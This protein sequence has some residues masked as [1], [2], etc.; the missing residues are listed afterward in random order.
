MEKAVAATSYS[1]IIGS[2]N[3]P[4]T[5]E[6]HYL[7]ILPDQKELNKQQL[8]KPL[9]TNKIFILEPEKEQIIT[10]NIHLINIE[11]QLNNL[12]YNQRYCFQFHH[13]QNTNNN[14]TREYIEIFSTYLYSNNDINTILNFITNAQNNTRY[15]ISIIK[16]EDS[17][18]FQYTFEDKNGHQ[19]TYKEDNIL[20]QMRQDYSLYSYY[21]Y[22]YYAKKEKL[23]KVTLLDSYVY[24][25]KIPSSSLL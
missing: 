8:L 3:D 14:Y 24:V 5:R 6:I 12:D 20:E 1:W 23:F 18:S 19:T 15:L 7:Y 25:R 16:H 22:D 11:E 4:L 2:Y 17:S 10:N 9:E 21:Y 13:E